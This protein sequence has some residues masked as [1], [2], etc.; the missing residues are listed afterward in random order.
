LGI[1]I[2]L[3]KGWWTYWRAPGASG[4]P[5]HF[6]WKGSINLAAP[7]ELAWPT[8]KQETVFGQALRIYENEVVLPLTI[9][10]SDSGRGVLVQ[11]GFT[12]AAC[13]D[14]CMPIR[15]QHVLTLA[16]SAQGAAYVDKRN[17]ALIDR[18]K[19]ELPTQD[20]RK[21]GLRILN[22]QA[23]EDEQGSS[24]T[25]DLSARR[26]AARPLILVELSP[27]QVPSVAQSRKTR[28][29]GQW[30]YVANWEPRTRR[31]KSLIGRRVR[32]TLFDGDIGCEQ[33]WVVG[34]HA[35]SSGAFSAG[36]RAGQMGDRFGS[37]DQPWKPGD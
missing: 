25:L 12:F 19:A 28:E 14:V 22:V 34:A 37:R 9:M 15:T 1:H 7:P 27:G 32:I 3:K 26:N 21:R 33:I 2:K 20:M 30:R 8:P 31:A 16:P 24:L 36:T 17:K 35:D 10:P 5:P 18:F 23:W 11:L 6:D 4:M 13:K 29:P